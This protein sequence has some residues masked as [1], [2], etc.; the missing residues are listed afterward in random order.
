[1]WYARF[2]DEQARDPFR[3]IGKANVPDTVYRESVVENPPEE[4]PKNEELRAK[5]ETKETW[6][7][8]ENAKNAQEAADRLF[9]GHKW[10]PGYFFH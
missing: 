4:E 10:K 7:R 6:R 2:W 3:N 5:A 9:P 1:M 8:K